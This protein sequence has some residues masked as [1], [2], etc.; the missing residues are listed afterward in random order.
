LERTGCFLNEA[1]K[2]H[3]FIFDDGVLLLT[4]KY[5]Y[6]DIFSAQNLKGTHNRIT[7]VSVK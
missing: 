6:F 7:A 1:K 2:N 4:V 5:D 3:Y